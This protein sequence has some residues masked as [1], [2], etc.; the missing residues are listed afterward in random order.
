MIN[1]IISGADISLITRYTIEVGQMVVSS[2]VLSLI[3][4]EDAVACGGAPNT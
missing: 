3:C 2:E 1:I 4:K